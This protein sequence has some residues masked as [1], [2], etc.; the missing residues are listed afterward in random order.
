MSKY[1]TTILIEIHDSETPFSFEHLKNFIGSFIQDNFDSDQEE[2]SG[3]VFGIEICDVDT[4]RSPKYCEKE[5][6]W[7]VRTLMRSVNEK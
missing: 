6:D 4:H 7:I 1:I 5:H 2:L 3:K